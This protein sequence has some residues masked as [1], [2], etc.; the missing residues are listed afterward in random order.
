MGI[1]SL[2][3][4]GII[5]LMVMGTASAQNSPADTNNDGCVDIGE[6]AAYV[7]HASLVAADDARTYSPTHYNMWRSNGYLKAVLKGGD[8]NSLVNI[9]N[10]AQIARLPLSVSFREG[11]KPVTKNDV[12]CVAIGPAEDWVVDLITGHLKLL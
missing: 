6:I 8:A 11:K 2:F 3:L 1:K 9:Y 7:A 10:A 12:A 4:V 5:L